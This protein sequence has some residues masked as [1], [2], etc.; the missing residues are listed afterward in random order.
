[1]AL[2]YHL[3]NT[4]HQVRQSTA[5]LLSSVPYIPISRRIRTWLT[6]RHRRAREDG[7]VL[8][9]IQMQMEG[10]FGAKGDSIEKN[11]RRHRAAGEKTLENRD[12]AIAD[13]DRIANPRQTATRISAALGYSLT[14]R[15]EVMIS[16]LMKCSARRLAVTPRGEAESEEGHS[17]RHSAG[18]GHE[19]PAHASHPSFTATSSPAIC[20]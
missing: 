8:G 17:L 16:E 3:H 4:Q 5:A 20:F 18:Q 1:M 12:A 10:N 14:N 11:E 9:D 6:E 19:L 2:S 7:S 15:H 13:S